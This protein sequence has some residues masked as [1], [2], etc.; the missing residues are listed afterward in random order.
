M[1]A[2]EDTQFGFVAT[3]GV[4][5]GDHQAAEALTLLA[6]PT[7]AGEFNTLGDGWSPGAVCDWRTFC[8]SS[9]RPLSSGGGQG[10][11]S[12]GGP[13]GHAQAGGCDEIIISRRVVAEVRRRRSQQGGLRHG[14]AG[15]GSVGKPFTEPFD[16]DQGA[17]ARFRPCLPPLANLQGGL[18][19]VNR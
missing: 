11:A 18:R 7:A 15:R 13:E 3:G 16:G 14:G 6:G 12:F 9:V 19:G 4:G 10:S 5:A 8:S 2:A 17:T 1:A